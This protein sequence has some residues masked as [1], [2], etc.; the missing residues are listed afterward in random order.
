MCLSNNHNSVSAKT[1][2]SLSN[3]LTGKCCWP[4]NENY[5]SWRI[6][7]VQDVC[8]FGSTIW[9]EIALILKKN[10]WW[11]EIFFPNKSKYWKTAS[12]QFQA[13][14][15][16]LKK[17]Q[18]HKDSTFTPESFHFSLWDGSH[19]VHYSAISSFTNMKQENSFF[20]NQFYFIFEYFFLLCYRLKK[21]LWF[22]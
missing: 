3:V 4:F 10:K 14:E 17:N 11:S 1:R 15:N 16:T 19:N 9:W 6:S 18:V 5:F 7:L 13:I 20:Y 2:K 21:L 12:P 22:M 8:V